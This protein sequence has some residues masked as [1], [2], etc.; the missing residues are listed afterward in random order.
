MLNRGRWLQLCVAELRVKTDA[1]QVF[2]M[3]NAGYSDQRRMY[4]QPKIVEHR[5][6]AY[7]QLL[8][9]LPRDPQIVELAIW[10]KDVFYF[11]SE[12]WGRLNADLARVLLESLGLSKTF[13]G[14]VAKLLIGQPKSIEGRVLSD[15][16]QRDLGEEPRDF[17]FSFRQIGREFEAFGRGSGFWPNRVQLFRKILRQ[18]SIYYTQLFYERYEALARENLERALRMSNRFI[19]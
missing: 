4:C 17:D 15:V 3:I 2:E 11:P 7:G 14:R 19:D 16:L 8:H 1:N 5:L 6:E 12:H 18:K 13:T 9:F 10:F